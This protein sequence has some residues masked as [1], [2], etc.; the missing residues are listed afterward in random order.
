M[1][2]PVA[3][4]IQALYPTASS[5]PST[6]KFVSGTLQPTGTVTNNYYYSLPT[7]STQPKYFGRLDYDVSPNNRITISDSEQND[8]APSPSF[9]AFPVG[10]Q[11]GDVENNNAQV[12][13][14]WTISPRLIN[15]ARFGFTAQLNYFADA[16]IGKGY[17]Q[18]F[19][20]QTAQANSLP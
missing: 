6:G 8:A 17:P 20:L 16:T 18:Q 7:A 14:V 2:N 3:L 11:S 9:F 5:N 13:D 12:S 4:K 19:G 15:Q 10:W 1:L